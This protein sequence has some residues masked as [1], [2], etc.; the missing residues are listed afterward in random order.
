MKSKSISSSI[1]IA[2]SL[3]VC[4]TVGLGQ[5]WESQIIPNEL[6]AITV[7]LNNAEIQRTAR[8]NLPSG[9][10]EIIFENISSRI[11]TK[12]IKVNAS[13]DVKVY[14]VTIENGKDSYKERQEYKAV[15]DSMRVLKE[16]K[17][18]IRYSLEVF[19]KQQLF[20]ESNMKINSSSS[21]SFS[22]IDEAE[23]YF[24]EKISR[25]Q[26][27][28][29]AAKRQLEEINDQEAQVLKM[30]ETVE[31]QLLKSNAKLKITLES[32]MATRQDLQVYFGLFDGTNIFPPHSQRASPANRCLVRRGFLVC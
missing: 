8:V 22:D 25:I 6:T 17:A 15:V 20:L 31:K 3:F 10:S 24:M 5:E 12:G 21:V 9:K 27:E 23:K 28:I 18:S 13:N 4:A 29:S 30:A 11:I 1:L 16:Q 26:T 7:F 2:L 14:A 19:Q 32:K